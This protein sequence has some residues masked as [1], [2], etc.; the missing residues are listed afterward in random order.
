[1]YMREYSHTRAG[2]NGLAKYRKSEKGKKAKLEY[3]RK[4]YHTAKGRTQSAYDSIVARCG[5]PVGRNSCYANIKCRFKNRQ[6]FVDYVL[7]ELKVDPR[8]LHI[9]RIDNDGHYEPGNIEFLT[10]DEHRRKH[11]KN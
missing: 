6:E 10:G 4:L 2:K 5:N 1:M 3:G 11:G 7:N 9:H 8:G